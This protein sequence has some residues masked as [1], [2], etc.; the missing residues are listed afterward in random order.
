MNVAGDR[1]GG[2][3]ERRVECVNI[4][5]RHRTFGVAD[6]RGDRH[7]GEAEI[8]GDAGKAVAQD[9]RGDTDERAVCEDLLPMVREA[10][11]RI[12][13]ALTGEDVGARDRP[14]L[15]GPVSMLVH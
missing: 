13:L 1:I 4:F 11:E 10:T 7:L 14:P 12:V 15:S 2:H 9:V 5:A 3:D 6:Q 8:V